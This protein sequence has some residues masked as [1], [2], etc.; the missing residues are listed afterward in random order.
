MSLIV[1]VHTRGHNLK[2]YKEQC[3]VN[4]RLNAF[5]RR[6]INVW[7]RLPAHVVNSGSIAVF[8]QRLACVNFS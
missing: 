7:N 1:S 2:L 8:K 6:N 3:N 5:V 4:C